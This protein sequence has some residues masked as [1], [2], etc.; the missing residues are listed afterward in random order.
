SK[1]ARPCFP[2]GEMETP[3]SPRESEVV[4]TEIVLPGD[5]NALGTAFGGK[6][7]QWI[8]TTAA[9]AAA[10]HT[11]KVVVTASM[12]ELHFHVPIKVGEIVQIHARVNAAFRHSLEVGVEVYAEDPIKG[13]RKHTC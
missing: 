3:R 8:D 13:T 2:G 9:I 12:D 6:V 4:T 7:M 1:S 10:R 5:G 11:R